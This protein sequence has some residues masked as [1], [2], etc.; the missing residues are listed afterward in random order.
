MDTT[1]L[2]SFNLV[3]TNEELDNEISDWLMHVQQRYKLIKF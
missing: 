2:S 1:Q 3:T